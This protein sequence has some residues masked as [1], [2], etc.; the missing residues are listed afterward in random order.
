M[1]LEDSQVYVYCLINQDILNY[2]DQYPR[3]KAWEILLYGASYWV[4]V[5]LVDN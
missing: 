5:M 2:Y 3:Q 1:F 4:T